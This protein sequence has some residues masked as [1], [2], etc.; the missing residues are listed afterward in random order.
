[1]YSPE[2]SAIFEGFHAGICNIEVIDTKPSMTV[3]FVTDVDEFP[4]LIFL[5]TAGTT[6]ETTLKH[7]STD[8]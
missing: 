5:F 7:E 2:L 6:L 3:Y 8:I 4:V 1:M